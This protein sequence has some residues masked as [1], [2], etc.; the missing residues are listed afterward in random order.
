MSEKEITKL[1]KLTKKLE[2]TEMYKRIME[3]SEKDEGNANFE[4]TEDKES[5]I[6]H[7]E[8]KKYDK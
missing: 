4:S 7:E 1:E 2:D 8:K 5:D 3:N 6:Y